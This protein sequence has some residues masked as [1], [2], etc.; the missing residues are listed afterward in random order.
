MG[1]TT[2][3]KVSIRIISATNKSLLEEVSN[4]NFREDLFYRLCVG[5]LNIAPLRDREGDI[6]LLIDKL[7]NKINE[8]S[9]GQPGYMKKKLSAAAKS[10]LMNHRW[11]GNVRELLNT[12]Q[13]AAVFSPSSTIEK[14]DVVEHIHLFP[15][16]ETRDIL[17]LVII[18]K[19]E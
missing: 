12:L 6:S 15:K 18:Y 14:R 17:G 13:A 3:R 19:N 4:G 11:P 10:I 16:E 5:V 8:D 7:M 2:A 9:I 1:S